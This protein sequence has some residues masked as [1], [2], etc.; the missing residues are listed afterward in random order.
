MI[1][2]VK[3]DLFLIFLIEIVEDVFEDI[4]FE[5]PEENE[6]FEEMQ[7]SEWAFEQFPEIPIPGMQFRYHNLEVTVFSM[8]QNRIRK[9]KL[10]VLPSE[11][12]GGEEA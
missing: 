5:D 4:D 7:M 6:D 12:E 9:L 10:A 3:Q 8:E 1:A 2:R 11:E